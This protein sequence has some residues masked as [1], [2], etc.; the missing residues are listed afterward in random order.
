MGGKKK[1]GGTEK[2][3]LI[4]DG[5]KKVKEK[6]PRLSKRKKPQGGE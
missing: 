1:D 6:S 3:G 5:A 4:S 2:G